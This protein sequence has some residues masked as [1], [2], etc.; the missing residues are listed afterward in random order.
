MMRNKG[1]IWGGGCRGTL[2]GVWEVPEE[3]GEERSF[4]QREQA[5]G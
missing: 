4:Q 5:A 2:G 1:Q 3:R